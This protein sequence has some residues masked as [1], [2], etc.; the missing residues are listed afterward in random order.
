MSLVLSSVVYS[1]PFE[2]RE[3]EDIATSRNSLDTFVIASPER[4]EAISFSLRL[5]SRSAPRNDTGPIARTAGC[6][7]GAGIK[8]GILAGIT[9]VRIAGAV[10]TGEGSWVAGR[11]E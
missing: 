7:T 3:G 1:N 9:G 4:G 5:L 8:T 2:V 10:Y 6:I 11:S